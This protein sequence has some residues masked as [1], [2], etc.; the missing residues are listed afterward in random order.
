MLLKCLAREIGKQALTPIAFRSSRL[1]LFLLFFFSRYIHLQCNSTKERP[2]RL[3]LVD[4]EC[5]HHDISAFL[6]MYE[7]ATI[8][9]Q[10][11][12]NIRALQCVSTQGIV[13]F[14]CVKPFFFFVLLLIPLVILSPVQMQRSLN[15]CGLQ[16][17]GEGCSTD[18]G[19]FT[20]TY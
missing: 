12:E 4:A 2:V 17:L 19:L 14:P 11:R 9:P 5:F 20:I 15:Y 1:R 16:F 6:Y 3:R 13:E 18:R 10:W 7:F 8:I